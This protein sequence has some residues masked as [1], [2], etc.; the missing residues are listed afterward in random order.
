MNIRPF[1]ANPQVDPLLQ[2]VQSRY[3][4]SADWVKSREC[5]LFLHEAIHYVRFRGRGHTGDYEEVAHY[6][7]GKIHESR[8]PV[9]L[10][11]FAGPWL[12][13]V[14]KAEL[15]DL[16]RTHRYFGDENRVKTAEKL[17]F[18]L[19]RSLA[20]FHPQS[21]DQ[22]F[23]GDP[24]DVLLLLRSTYLRRNESLHIDLSK[25]FL[26][27]Y[28]RE[29][30]SPLHDPSFK[31]VLHQCLRK[32]GVPFSHVDLLQ[33]VQEDPA[34]KG[35]SMARLGE[36]LQIWLAAPP[37]CQSAIEECGQLA[38]WISA[39]FPKA[40]APSHPEIESCQ[41]RL[42]EALRTIP[43]PLNSACLGEI[44]RGDR[45]PD[46]R[47][48]VLESMARW[49]T[50]V[51]GALRQ[52]RAMWA[53]FDSDEQLQVLKA[54]TRCA[55]LGKVRDVETLRFLVEAFQEGR[56]RAE[57]VESGMRF[58]VQL[59]NAAQCS[60]LGFIAHNQ[61][62]LR[63][64]LQKDAP[65]VAL[66]L[67]Q[68]GLALPPSPDALHEKVAQDFR[69]ALNAANCH[70]PEEEVSTMLE[71]LK[72]ASFDV[73]VRSILDAEMDRVLSDQLVRLDASQR[74]E[75]REM[76]FA[77][78][79]GRMLPIVLKRAL[80]RV[81]HL[82]ADQVSS[83]VCALAK[84]DRYMALK[85]WLQ[86][87]CPRME[88]EQLDRLFAVFRGFLNW[89]VRMDAHLEQAVGEIARQLE[90]LD[91]A[92]HGFCS[93]R[94]FAHYVLATLP[95]RSPDQL[96][97]VMAR[98]G[99][100]EDFRRVLQK[101]CDSL[102]DVQ[103][104]ADATALMFVGHAHG[105]GAEPRFLRGANLAL[106][107]P[108]AIN[109]S[110]VNQ[111]FV[112]SGS[113]D[114]PIDLE[115]LRSMAL[116]PY[117]YGALSGHAKL[118]PVQQGLFELLTSFMGDNPQAL[119][120]DQIDLLKGA[121]RYAVSETTKFSSHFETKV[122][123]RTTLHDVALEDVLTAL[124]RKG[125]GIPP[126]D[127]FRLLVES[128]KDI[129]H[130]ARVDQGVQAFC[131]A[132]GTTVAN[133]YYLFAVLLARLS[134]AD[135]LGWEV[136]KE[137]AQERNVSENQ[138]LVGLRLLSAYCLAQCRAS[139]PTKG[140]PSEALRAMDTLIHRLMRTEECASELSKLLHG[141]GA[142]DGLEGFSARTAELLE[143]VV[144]VAAK[145]ARPPD[146]PF[147]GE[148]AVQRGFMTS[149]RRP[150]LGASAVRR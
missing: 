93:P 63:D 25:E 149:A 85:K 129:P 121:I 120:A 30:K 14:M 8:L 18:L 35:L 73:A 60:A 38:Q 43:R 4:A 15:H 77:Q 79:D 147:M 41:R 103:D 1:A 97:S 133:A 107:H 66:A 126:A 143:V 76:L 53:D 92:M 46:I 98:P 81:E 116:P 19:D 130:A 59:F 5:R 83:L 118:S 36:L 52:L 91:G 26:F 109:F 37:M 122:E 20:E 125:R 96:K 87:E 113:A 58:Y 42:L 24:A 68:I 89:R 106:F 71:G 144:G 135:G 127:L 29:E 16:L 84:N 51:D 44:M 139:L 45:G 64:Q 119:S 105:D 115:D 90:D 88:P 128:Q 69:E 21:R 142:A 137:R 72:H 22:L 86:G 23:D 61:L 70:P 123:M 10:Q 145:A 2:G 65:G 12:T 54:A 111:F 55:D 50:G 57:H 131:Q 11:E 104:P 82:F 47:Q 78:S 99:I 101:A 39:L 13:P 134:S 48:V 95:Y 80:D 112:R 136:S 74:D 33:M 40:G 62:W 7:M 110:N 32:E 102:K 17:K 114:R 117:L 124:N 148:D 141:R 132:S 6:L 9:A 56:I 100:H 3:N 49:E 138:S 27:R 67:H 108:Q 75:I 146:L 94:A 150:R 31:I 28:L 34:M 140:A